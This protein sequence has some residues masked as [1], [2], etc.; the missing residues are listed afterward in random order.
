MKYPLTETAKAA[1]RDIVAAWDDGSLDQ[2]FGVAI[3]GPQHNQTT[4]IMTSSP[5]DLAFRSPAVEIWREFQE[6]KLIRN[7]NWQIT[8][9]EE[10]RNAV[11]TDFDVSDYF[12]TMNA[13]GNI[14][15]NSTTG[16][17]QGVGI[18]TGNVQQ[19]LEQLSDD[20]VAT[21]SETL[22][23]TQL[24]LRMAI[25]DL[26][27]ATTADCEPKLGKVISELGRC[28]QHGANTVTILSALNMVVGFIAQFPK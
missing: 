16:P 4:M 17:V 11:R 10:L 6:Y 21:L 26:K 23:E 24:E 1:A 2:K 5:H 28:L 20:L 19:T 15:V 8:L 14:I 7:D 18:N 9:L 27:M 25:D 12:V 22:L 13:V 3:F